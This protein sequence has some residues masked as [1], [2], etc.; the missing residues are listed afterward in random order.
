MDL[1]ILFNS[2]FFLFYLL[3]TVWINCNGNY[4]TQNS[5]Q[6]S[7]TQ[8]LILAPAYATLLT[9]VGLYSVRCRTMQLAQANKSSPVFFALFQRSCKGTS[10]S[11][12]ESDNLC[13]CEWYKFDHTALLLDVIHQRLLY[14]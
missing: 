1:F 11:P 7:A 12:E 9:A 10:R 3:N 14:C 8:C 13:Y 6:Y 2:F 4:S 5:L